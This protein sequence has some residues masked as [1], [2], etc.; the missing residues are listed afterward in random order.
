[1]HVLFSWRYSYSPHMTDE[2]SPGPRAEGGCEGRKGLERGNSLVVQWLGL[3]TCTA[4]GPGL[5][6]GWGA[7]VL[8]NSRGVAP[9]PQNI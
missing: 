5:I 3:C 1:M 4:K 7:K 2:R 6:P 8:H 9:S